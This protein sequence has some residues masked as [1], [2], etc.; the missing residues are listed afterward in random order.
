MMKIKATLHWSINLLH[1]SS[2]NMNK[3]NYIFDTASNVNWLCMKTACYVSEI[4][5]DKINNLNVC[6]KSSHKLVG[7][8][9]CNDAVNVW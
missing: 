5:V 9:W 1:N 3:N 7:K 4:V 8:C 6:R 2:S